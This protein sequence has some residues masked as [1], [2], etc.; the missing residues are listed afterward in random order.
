[1]DLVLWNFVSKCLNGFVRQKSFKLFSYLFLD[2]SFSK[3]MISNLVFSLKTK[4]TLA[5]PFLSLSQ[6]SDQESFSIS[7]WRKSSMIVPILDVSWMIIFATKLQSNKPEMMKVKN[8]IKSGMQEENRS[9][10]YFSL[11]AFTLKVIKSK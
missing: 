7:K 3:T 10:K 1:M 9:V 5:K 8:K 2:Q 6:V 11:F 4:L